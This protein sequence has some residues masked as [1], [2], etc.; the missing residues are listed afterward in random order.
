MSRSTQPAAEKIAHRKRMN[1]AKHGHKTCSKA[2][3]SPCDQ[4]PLQQDTSAY[5][6]ESEQETWKD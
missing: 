5:Q 6:D 2:P 4:S 1:T 3:L